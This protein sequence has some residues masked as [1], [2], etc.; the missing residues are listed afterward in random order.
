M[1]THLARSR[2]GALVH[3][4]RVSEG[5]FKAGWNT[6]GNVMKTSRDRVKRTLYSVTE[7]KDNRG[8]GRITDVQRGMNKANEASRK[9][10]QLGFNNENETTANDNELLWYGDGFDAEIDSELTVIDSIGQRLILHIDNVIGGGG[11]RFISLFC[12]YWIV[13]TTSHSLRYKQEKVSGYV[14]GTVISQELDGSK[15]VDSSN[16]NDEDKHVDVLSSLENGSPYSTIFSGKPGALHKQDGAALE[17]AALACL[18]SEDLP[19][20]IMSNLA[21]MFNFQETISLGTPMRLCVQLA[22]ATSG[23]HHISAWSSGFGLESVG[24]TQIVG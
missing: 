23:S 12:P 9:V 13:N 5:L 24:V 18:I 10:G 3:N 2:E 15:R 1:I 17:P 20:S 16:R 11:Q 19:L 7:S 8:A 4:G 14:S 21:F 22:D 6:L